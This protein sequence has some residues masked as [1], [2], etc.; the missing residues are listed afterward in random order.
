MID[1]ADPG[2]IANPKATDLPDASLQREEVRNRITRAIDSLSIDHKEVILLKEVEGMS[3]QEIADSID[4]STGTVMS[5]L[6]YARK[7]LKEI[8]GDIKND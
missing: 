7:K 3:Y 4:C 5:R 8:L 2:G 1:Q 6:F